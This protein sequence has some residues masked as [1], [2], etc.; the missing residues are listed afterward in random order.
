MSGDKKIIKNSSEGYGY[1]YASLADFARQGVDIPVMRTVVNE[2]GEFVEYKDANDR[3]QQGARVVAMQMKGMNEAQA[4]GSA[5]TYARRYTV[6]LANGIATDDDDEIE[7]AKPVAKKSKLD[8][9]DVWAKLDKID[10]IEELEEYWHS[11]NLS[12]AQQKALQKSFAKR[13]G[14]LNGLD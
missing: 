10:S 3:W 9:Q 8:F 13:K 12:P 11:L 14:E 4:Y 1:H 5:L 2:F 7:K 6:A